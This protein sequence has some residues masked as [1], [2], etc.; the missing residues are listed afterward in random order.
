MLLVNTRAEPKELKSPVNLIS[1]VKNAV[2]ATSDPVIS[3]RGVFEVRLTA[4]FEY[5]IALR[6]RCASTVHSLRGLS[7]LGDMAH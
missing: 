7:Q 4:Y 5:P 1:T 3:G 2:I 6:T